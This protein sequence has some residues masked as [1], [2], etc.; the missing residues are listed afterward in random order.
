MHPAN[1]HRGAPP[2]PTQCP[3]QPSVDRV[4]PAALA[5]PLADISDACA[6]QDKGDGLNFWSRHAHRECTRERSRRPRGF[7]TYRCINCVFPE[8]IISL[9]HGRWS[10]LFI[11][12][13]AAS[14]SIM[15]YPIT[16]LRTLHRPK[17][18]H[19]ARSIKI[20]GRPTIH[21]ETKSVQPTWEYALRLYEHARLQYGG[22]ICHQA[23]VAHRLPIVVVVV[24]AVVQ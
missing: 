8:G 20:S 14:L 2:C 12:T 1:S 22:P 10:N 15:N 21:Y 23:G 18:S 24:F 6:D 17:S 16:K 7:C 13:S 9:H 5:R 4:H 19:F 3:T 11:Q